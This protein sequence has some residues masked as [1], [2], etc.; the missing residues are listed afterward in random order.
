MGAR[1]TD[2]EPRFLPYFSRGNL[3]DEMTK[4]SVTGNY[5]PEKRLLEL[6]HG[7]CLAWV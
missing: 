1:C 5:M 2:S 3:Q 4:S 6:F 7:T